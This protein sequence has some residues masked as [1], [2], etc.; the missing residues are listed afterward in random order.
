MLNIQHVKLN[1]YINFNV[2]ARPFLFHR[3]TEEDVFLNT[4]V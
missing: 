2:A 4:R 1:M 3:T